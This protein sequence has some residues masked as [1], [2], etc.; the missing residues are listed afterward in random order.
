MM[1]PFFSFIIPVYNVE[2]Y[3]AECIESI[4]N[5]SFKNYEIILVNDGSTDN[6]LEICKY[7]QKKD[8]RIKVLTK[9]NAGLSHTRNTGLNIATGE[10]IFFLDSDDHLEKQGACLGEIHLH[11]LESSADIF[12]FDLIR[13]NVDENDKYCLHENFHCEKLVFIDDIED[14]LNK[15]KYTTSACNKIIKKSLIDSKGL[16]FLEGVLSEDVSWCAELLN[17]SFSMQYTNMEIYFYRQNRSG[18]IMSEISK[19]HIMDVHK[20]LVIFSSDFK[21]K[22]NKYLKNYLSLNYLNC[23]RLMCIHREFS[24]IE[25]IRLM[26]PISFYLDGYGNSKIIL[27]KYTSKIIG[28]KSTIRFLRLYLLNVRR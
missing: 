25:L 4:L 1:R 23:L 12:M 8:N 3:L 22:S 13:F 15:K 7:Y 27:L 10:Y 20:Q 9:P 26:E 14:I 19:K 18:S 2:D 17:Y 11:L 21:G 5:Q 24:L 6:S 16:R 28:F